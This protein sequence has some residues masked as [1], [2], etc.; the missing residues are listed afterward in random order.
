[1]GAMPSNLF[2]LNGARISGIRGD[3]AGEQLHPQTITV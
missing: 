3:Y 1:M 2:S